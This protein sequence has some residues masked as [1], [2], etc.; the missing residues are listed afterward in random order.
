MKD[1]DFCLWDK[2]GTLEPP[3]LWPKAK[4]PSRTNDIFGVCAPTPL[5]DHW[6]KG[7]CMTPI[8]HKGKVVGVVTY[9]SALKHEIKHVRKLGQ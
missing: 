8:Y 5:S 7:L 6:H 3:V 9:Q 4:H 2:G 1:G